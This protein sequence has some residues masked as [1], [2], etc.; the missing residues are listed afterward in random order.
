[1]PDD[2]LLP[3][4]VIQERTS[5]AGLSGQRPCRS[6]L[7]AREPL[8][9]CK[10]ESE[11]ECQERFQTDKAIMASLRLLGHRQQHTVAHGGPKVAK[12]NQ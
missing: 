7:I 3:S 2:I 9:T 5:I 8:F 4:R 10:I 1:M 11:P 12:R 6:I